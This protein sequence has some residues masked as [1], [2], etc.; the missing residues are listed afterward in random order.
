MEL[1]HLFDDVQKCNMA[2]NNWLTP[3]HNT[4]PP[5]YPWP[6]Y[7]ERDSSPY[8]I[9]PPHYPWPLVQKER[10]LLTSCR[11]SSPP[12]MASN[13]SSV[14]SSEISMPAILVTTSR[15]SNKSKLQ[16]QKNIN[17]DQLWRSDIVAATKALYGAFR[18]DGFIRGAK[19]IWNFVKITKKISLKIHISIYQ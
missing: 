2:V 9:T 12:D 15:N 7:T 13:W 4:P 1:P 16:N 11:N 6:W 19:N 5:H 18:W 17:N 10:F 14:I 8:A 3:C